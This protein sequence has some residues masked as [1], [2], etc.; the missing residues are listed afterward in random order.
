MGTV[1]A[2]K[3]G[4]GPETDVVVKVSQQRERILSL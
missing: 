2:E 4:K 3:E 1:L